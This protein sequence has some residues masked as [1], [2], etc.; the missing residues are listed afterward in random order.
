MVMRP[1]TET[2]KKESQL[3]PWEI[4]NGNWP[5][6]LQSVKQENKGNTSRRWKNIQG[7]RQTSVGNFGQSILSPD[8]KACR[9]SL[10]ACVTGKPKAHAKWWRKHKEHLCS[11]FCFAFVNSHKNWLYHTV[12]AAFLWLNHRTWTIISRII[13]SSLPRIWIWI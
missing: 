9:C 6:G 8:R 2:Q 13:F 12:S 4:S 1:G 10:S 11:R 3:L 5:G 7:E